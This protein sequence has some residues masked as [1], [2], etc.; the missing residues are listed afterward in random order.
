MHCGTSNFDLNQLKH[1]AVGSIKIAKTFTKKHP[2]INTIINGK[3][4][5]ESTY[6]YRRTKTDKVDQILRVEFKNL[7]QTYF[8][9]Q[10][11]GWVNSNR[12]LDENFYYKDFLQLVETGNVKFSKSICLF[13]RQFFTESRRLP[14][15]SLLSFYVH[16]HYRYFHH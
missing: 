4:T 5:R 2:K 10:D 13:L 9:D 3:L 7:P 14:S 15:S 11:G 12:V 6:S 1:I 8:L 16:Q